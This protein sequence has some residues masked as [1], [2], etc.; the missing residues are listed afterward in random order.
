MKPGEFS[1]KMKIDGQQLRIDPNKPLDISI[2]IKHGEKNPICYHSDD[3]RIQ[4]VEKPGF[5]GSVARGGSCNHNVITL[6]PHGNG[7]HTEC[8]GH[9]SSD[10]SVTLNKCLKRFHFNAQLISVGSVT[11]AQSDLVIPWNAI[12]PLLNDPIPEALIIRTLPNSRGKLKAQYSGTNPPYLGT[13]VTKNIEAMNIRHLLVDLPSVDKEEDDGNLV[14]HHEFWNYPES[15]RADCTITELIF[16]P[17]SIKDG[18]YLLNLQI[19]SLE[20]DASPSKPIL[21]SLLST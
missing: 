3:P 1:L 12:K 11:S 19:I 8:Y 2:P 21:Y 18:R 5:I 4:P 7:T 10:S 16:V 20:S 13:G 17:D 9:I 6:T 15:P 14:S